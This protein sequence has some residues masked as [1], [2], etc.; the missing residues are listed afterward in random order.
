M[1]AESYLETL[2]P[3]LGR[4]VKEYLE[5]VERGEKPSAEDWI[6]RHGE[7]AQPLRDFCL[8]YK[9]KTGDPRFETALRNRASK[10]FPQ[11]S[12]PVS[13]ADFHAAPGDGVL[14][15]TEGELLRQA[16]LKAGDVIVALAGIRM[17]NSVQ[18]N[19]QRDLSTDPEMILIVWQ[20]DQYRE[21]KASPP[22]HRFGVKIGNY[23]AK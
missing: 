11:G 20:G 1:P 6:N 19:F 15:Q 22:N 2:D 18:Y 12:E 3:R 14:I 8:R 23:K 5:A 10:I 16:G 9:T 7:F 17:H 13:L 4:I 21:I